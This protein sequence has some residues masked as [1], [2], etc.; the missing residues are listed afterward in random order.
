MMAFREAP[1]GVFERQLQIRPRRGV[2]QPRRQG[3]DDRVALNR[4]GFP[5]T[6][7]LGD[8]KNGEVEDYPA[9]VKNCVVRLVREARAGH[10]AEW[11]TL[12][13]TASEI[14]CSL[15]TLPRWVRGV[16][17]PYRPKPI[18]RIGATRSPGSA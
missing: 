14:G 3:I 1:L 10:P 5:E 6:R 4:P 13:S 2:G 15:K 9:E 7:M 11:N 16:K 17:C 8:W 12:R 18:A